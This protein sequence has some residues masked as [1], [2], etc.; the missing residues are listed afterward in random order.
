M[1][2]PPTNY[3]IQKT[4][5]IDEERV[6]S[7]EA[8]YASLDEYLMK[9]IAAEESNDIKYRTCSWQKTAALLF[10]E[11]IC[12]AIMSFPWSYSVLGLVPGLIVTGFVSLTTLY[13]G[14]VVWE[15]CLKNPEVKDVCDIGQKLF[16]GQ[17]WAWYFTAVCFLLNNVFIQ[18]LHVLVG[19]EY[20]NTVSN[21]GL[22]TVVFAALTAIVCFFFS[23]PRTFANLSWLATF[24]AVTMFLAVLLS[25]IFAAIQSHP[26]GFVPGEPVKWNLF[27]E[28]GTTYVQ[29]MSATLNIVYT[30]VGQITYPSFIAEMKDPREFKRALLAITA[31]E[32]I[33]FSL[34]GS[35]IYV[36][37]GNSYITAPAFG[38]L[39]QPYKIIAFSFAIPT[40]VFLGVLYASVSARFI[41]IRLFQ[42]SA[43]LGAHTWT[44]W[45]TWGG[46]LLL[47][48]AIAFVIAESIP[49]FS[50]LL[51]LMSSLFDCWFG[52][53]FWGVAYLQ[54]RQQEFGQ[55]WWKSLNAW[56]YVKLAINI[57]MIVIGLYI[58]GPGTYA[59]VE[60]IIQ[61]FQQG[62]VKGVFRCAS[63]GI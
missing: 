9:Q 29:A 38:S 17:N 16:W 22:C 21:H 52:Y 27:P 10:S 44:G 5:S 1:A 57:G 40:I 30:F 55:G 48:W 32:L 25:I 15:F 26:A 51:S 47:L 58:L 54:L 62:L 4:E 8:E 33:V 11:Y 28:K 20:L 50:D 14:L 19:A 12:L 7:Q 2:D 41:F 53:V 6:S 43:H 13:T 37:V 49:F 46:I 35:I 60:S 34:A 39:S 3:A 24:S 31:A 42:D 56:G 61:S 45:L 63:N 18:G 59:T 23:L 36:Y